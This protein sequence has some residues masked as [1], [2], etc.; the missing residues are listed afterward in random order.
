MK[1]HQSVNIH[2]S[3]FFHWC[4]VFVEK[5]M[6]PYTNQLN[7]CWH[8]RT[9]VTTTSVTTLPSGKI[10]VVTAWC[11]GVFN[12][13]NLSGGKPRNATTPVTPNKIHP[14]NT[15]LPSDANLHPESSHKLLSSISSDNPTD[16]QA[17]IDVAADACQRNLLTDGDEWWI[18]PENQNHKQLNP[19]LTP[20]IM[21]KARA[22]LC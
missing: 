12:G 6:D 17:N 5:F 18:T 14:A 2:Q 4:R 8:H 9:G 20:P 22:V 19:P 15:T 10:V 3:W 7:T 1:E 21:A 16:K 11:S 13:G